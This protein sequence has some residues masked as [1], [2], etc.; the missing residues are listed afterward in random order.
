MFILASALSSLAGAAPQSRR[1]H[2]ECFVACAR[3]AWQQCRRTREESVAAIMTCSYVSVVQASFRLWLCVSIIR[4]VIS[5]LLLYCIGA[6][7]VACIYFIVGVFCVIAR[8]LHCAYHV[9]PYMVT[10]DIVCVVFIIACWSIYVYTN[11]YQQHFSIYIY[12]GR[13]IHI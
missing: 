8:L 9:L 6:Q 1:P 3:A 11:M 13:G 7:L 5:F 10:C 4:H 12:I 2:S